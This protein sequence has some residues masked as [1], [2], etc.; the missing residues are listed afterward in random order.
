MFVQRALFNFTLR[1][2]FVVEE[3]DDLR[4]DDM[5]VMIHGEHFFADL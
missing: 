3:G 2:V 4:R 5:L 1:C